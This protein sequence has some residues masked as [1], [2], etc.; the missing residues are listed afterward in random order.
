MAAYIDKDILDKSTQMK[1]PIFTLLFLLFIG[2]QARAQSYCSPD[3]QWTTFE[4]IL[5]SHVHSID[6]TEVYNDELYILAHLTTGNGQ[7]YELF[8]LDTVGN[9]WQSMSTFMS[10]CPI[11]DMMHFGGDI[12]LSGGLCIFDLDPNAD[13]SIRSI[14][15][16]DGTQWHAV[17]QITDISLL[18]AIYDLETYNGELYATGFFEDSTGDFSGIARFDGTNWNSMGAGLGDNPTGSGLPNGHCLAVY[19][20][21]LYVGGEFET[22]A[23]PANK[24]IASWNGTA[25]GAVPSPNARVKS[26]VGTDTCLMV[27]AVD[28]DTFGTEEIFELAYLQNGQWYSTGMQQSDDCSYLSLIEFNNEI[29]VCLEWASI[30]NGNPN[31]TVAKYGTGTWVPLPEFNSINLS[32][33]NYQGRLLVPGAPPITSCG[34][35]ID[36]LGVLCDTAHCGAISGRV[37]VDDNLNCQ[38]NA[39]PALPQQILTLAPFNTTISTDS[40]GYYSQLLPMGNY[41]IN[42]QAPTWYSVH[43]PGNQISTTVLQGANSSGV[44]FALEATPNIQDIR[45]TLTQGL[46]RV[47]FPTTLYITAMNIGTVPTTATNIDITYSDTLVYD[48]TNVTL[49][50]LGGNL[51][52]WNIG[53]L[54][55]YEA[56]TCQVYLTVP[57]NIALLGEVLI[58]SAQSITPDADATNDE[59]VV[60]TVVFAAYDPN[61]K[62]VEPVGDT[63]NSAPGLIPLTTDE[64]TYTIYFQN[65]GNDTAFTVTLLDELNANLDASTL[66]LL[67]SSH[68]VEMNLMANNTVEFVFNNILLPDSTT[69]LLGSQG[70]VKFRIEPN[71]GMQDGDQITN[72]A[73]IYFDFNPAIT[74]NTVVNTYNLAISIAQNEKQ[75]YTIQAHPNPFSEST[76]ISVQGTA[77]ANN[78]VTMQLFDIRGQL[79]RSFSGIAG[80]K[81]T[82][83]RKELASGIYILSVSQG[84]E[85]LGTNKLVVR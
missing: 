24:R 29:F 15:R 77:L 20:G 65:T 41:T 6:Q 46:A 19:D 56:K 47:G 27:H 52:N 72:Y 16:F 62:T 54:G 66:Q 9:A 70:F 42:Y 82:L 40:S 2:V 60:S 36:R 73:E 71:A 81:H 59:D 12:Y 48:S 7:D 43:C 69:N 53:S 32:P 45:V 30:L 44:D 38:D 1:R 64:F 8:K 23:G 21:L 10:S 18:G 51:L 5:P 17:P 31:V 83:S 74:T 3:S 22:T 14:A 26:M 13:P 49:N 79:V 50:T 61:K 57:P 37:Y 80:E 84:G 28:A 25:W 78:R 33:A 76:T 11:A 63:A 75:V 85:F 34:T 35:T 68:I 39:D 4:A 58:S 55:V 67:S